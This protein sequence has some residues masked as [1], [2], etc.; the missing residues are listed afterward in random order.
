MKKKVLISTGGSGGHVIPATILCDH[1]SETNEVIIST[2]KRGLRYLDKNSYEIKVI[3]TPRFNNIL[4]LPLNLIIIFL[5]I[6]KS[7]F[8]LR[9]NK[10]NFLISTGGYMSLPLILA[11]KF[12]GIKIFL[13]E[14][15][16]V[17]G[18]ANKFF[19]NSCKKI[20]CYNDKLKNFPN[21][22]EDKIV[23]IN[24]LIRKEFYEIEEDINPN[25]E[26]RILV[27]GGSQGAEVFDN[28]L[29]DSIINLSK[30]FSIKIIQQTNQKNISNLINLYTQNGI[31]N[32]IFNYDN[33]FVNCI[34][35]SDI[36]IT[37][38]GA[39]TLAELSFLNVPFIA[40]PLPSSK[41]NHQFENANFY[42]EKKC[43]WIIEQNLFEKNIE[44]VLREI[45]Q[46]KSDFLEKKENLKK[47]NYQNSWINVN[48]KILKSINEN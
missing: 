24:P 7:F 2:D 10:I 22:F 31:K 47:L 12:I 45:I 43:C 32:Q 40:I 25:T 5:Q 3:D 38:A 9:K 46:N 44:E 35:Q 48:Q 1:L 4:S 16:L 34:S 27:V 13:L 19:L 8:L 6:I 39:T 42:F 28:K 23:K 36:C 18:R 20:F 37:R 26:F 29:K 17:L 41:D 33:D 14:P 30:K 21:N 15:N 11:S